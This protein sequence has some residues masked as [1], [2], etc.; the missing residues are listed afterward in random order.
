MIKKLSYTDLKKK[1]N[2]G[3]SNKLSV[4]ATGI[5]NYMYTTR[6]VESAG[7]GFV[8]ITDRSLAL[9]DTFLMEPQPGHVVAVVNTGIYLLVAITDDNK[10]GICARLELTSPSF[11]YQLP[12]FTITAEPNDN[13]SS[14]NKFPLENMFV[15]RK[16]S[17]DMKEV[18]QLYDKFKQLWSDIHKIRSEKQVIE[19]GF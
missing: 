12:K 15:L 11:V 4:K 7:K 9:I 14:F 3:D 10:T 17:F 18:E 16:S 6:M 1:I 8:E 5:L 19:K 2:N 13:M